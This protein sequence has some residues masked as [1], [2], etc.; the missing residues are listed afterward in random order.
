MW[1]VAGG[2]DCY[3]ISCM[4]LCTDITGLRAGEFLWGVGVPWLWDT[5][6][7]GFLSRIWNN[8]NYQSY[9]FWNLVFVSSYIIFKDLSENT[10][11]NSMSGDL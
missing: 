6:N 4:C 7:K 1:Q 9:Y 11:K 3:K 2:R 5:R 10:I 8:N